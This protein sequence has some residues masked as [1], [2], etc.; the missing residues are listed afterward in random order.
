LHLSSWFLHERRKHL[1]H[2]YTWLVH[3]RYV[4]LVWFSRLDSSA[5]HNTCRKDSDINVGILLQVQIAVDFLVCIERSGASR[6]KLY[7]KSLYMSR[8]DRIMSQYQQEYKYPRC[9]AKTKFKCRPSSPQVLCVPPLALSEVYVITVSIT[10]G[11]RCGCAKI[12]GAF[13]PSTEIAW[14]AA[15]NTSTLCGPASND[16][17]LHNQSEFLKRTHVNWPVFADI[18]SIGHSGVVDSHTVNTRL[19]KSRVDLLRTQRRAYS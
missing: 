12:L 7:H 9:W 6:S 14:T 4:K 13:R 3:P 8:C 5:Q 11:T 1:N 10:P 16:I 2:V 15:F 18:S 19:V 17:S